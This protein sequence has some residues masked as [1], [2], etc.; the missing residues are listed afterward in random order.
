MADLDDGTDVV[1]A[2]AYRPGAKHLLV[3]SDGRGFIASADDLVATTRKGRNVLSVDAPGRAVV[4]GRGRRR[5]RCDRRR[6]PQAAGLP[7]DP[8]SRD[9]A[10]E[11]VRLQRYREAQVSDAKTFNLADGLTWKDASGRTWTV[12]ADD[13]KDWISHRAEAG[14]LPPKGFPKTNKF[15]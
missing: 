4:L 2:F 6:Q 9:V 1:A 7:D 10:R 3:A 15:G 14:R 8:T 5:P 12:S 11:G 13:L